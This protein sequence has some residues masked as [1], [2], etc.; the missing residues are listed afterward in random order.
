MKRNQ[1]SIFTTRKLVMMAVLIAI[2]IVLSRYLAIQVSPTLRI[3]FETIPLA[4][5]GMWLGPLGGVIVALVS[6]VLGTFIYGYGV[7]FPPIALGPALFAA[8][9]GWGTKYLFRSNLSE[10]KDAWKVI[11]ITAV[12]GIV[13]AFVIGVFTTTLYSIIIGGR[14]FTFTELMKAFFDG[15]VMDQIM[16]SVE[17]G[18]FAATLSANFLSRL[19]SKPF[20]V[21]ACSVLIALIHRTV[22]R[23]VISRIVNRTK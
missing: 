16:A 2:Q 17:S 20:V 21:A 22:Y 5:A 11:V 3:S 12:A 19:A 23:P 1:N 10:T 18:K 14:E 4:F 6:D 8:M 9:C 13:N 7:W 15:T